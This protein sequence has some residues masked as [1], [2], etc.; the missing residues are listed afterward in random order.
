MNRF[1]EIKGKKG[2]ATYK[3]QNKFLYSFYDPYAEAEKFIKSQQPLKQNIITI[4][5]ANYINQA[6]QTLPNKLIFSYST[7]IFLI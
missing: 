4:C 1:K 3:N 5:G 6:L 7:D 2:H